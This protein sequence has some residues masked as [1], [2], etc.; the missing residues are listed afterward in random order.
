MAST[1]SDERA[2]YLSSR[3]EDTH[4]LR[5]RPN[6]NAN[7]GI[8]RKSEPTSRGTKS[9]NNTNNN[10]I[11]TG[12]FDHSKSTLMSNAVRGRT[13]LLS[14]IAVLIMLFLYF[15][16]SSKS[17]PSST[18][19]RYLTWEEAPASIEEFDHD[20]DKR[21]CR[22]PILSVEEWEM[23][24]YWEREMPVIVKN[25]TDGWPALEHWTK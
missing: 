18:V 7:G 4:E 21:V 1:T 10:D 15:G 14:C 8:R 11:I 17:Q 5:I 24:R 3:R 25:V 23:G 13:F 2:V 22:L 19:G 12:E 6:A 20:N 16:S 9:N